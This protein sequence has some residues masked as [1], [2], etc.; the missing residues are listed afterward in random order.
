LLAIDNPSGELIIKLF[1]K[2]PPFCPSNTTVNMITTI[3]ILPA[4]IL[5][6][7]FYIRKSKKENENKE[8]GSQ[9][10]SIP[11]LDVDVQTEM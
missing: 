6:T 4:G 1:S 2:V 5:S 8:L 3:L 10:S 7:E 11:S 9:R